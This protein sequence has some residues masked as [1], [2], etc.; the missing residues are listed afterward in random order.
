MEP[1]ASTTAAPTTG[2]GPKK[3]LKAMKLAKDMTPDERMIE[4]EKRAGQREVAKN[5]VL[6]ARLDEER[7]QE[8]ERYL[9][10]QALAN[11]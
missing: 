11:I 3:Q 4:S 2:S 10:M 6:A 7:G 8:T 1:A 5:R 9:V